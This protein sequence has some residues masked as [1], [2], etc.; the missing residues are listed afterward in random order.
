MGVK[1]S[2]EH[3]DFEL[4]KKGKRKEVNYG[5]ETED[6]SNWSWRVISIV[7]VPPL[8]HT[9][10]VDLEMAGGRANNILLC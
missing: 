2:A 7:L 10:A 5:V 3:K 8:D 9:S 4:Y 1:R 6:E